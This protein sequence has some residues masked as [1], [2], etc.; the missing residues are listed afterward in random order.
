MLAIKDVKKSFK[1]LFAPILNGVSLSLKRGDFCILIGA[2]GCGKSTL[3]KIISGECTPD[4]GTIERQGFVAQV[5]QEVYL[6]TVSE[7]TL[8]EN[9]AL[10]C[11]KTPNLAFYKRHEN[12]II[13]KIEEL[14][15]GLEKYL[16]QP[17]KI[18]SG[19]QRQ[20]IATLM[21]LVS[22]PDILLLDE[23]TSALDPKMQ[24]VLMEYTVKQIA[25]RNLTVLM[26]THKMDDAI[27]YGNRLVM[28][29]E[30]K[31]LS[32]FTG[33]EKKELSSAHLLT[34]FHKYEDET[35]LCGGSHDN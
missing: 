14:G 19:G 12:Y 33:S 10:S 31:V 8:L 17:L 25:H 16:H 21:V 7:M 27:K 15:M 9:I 23:H 13:S 22:E 30:G 3:F 29:H 5:S 1:N 4:S 34:L 35:L 20:I 6:G 28:L 24:S 2:N 32:D 18:L 26:I 11:I